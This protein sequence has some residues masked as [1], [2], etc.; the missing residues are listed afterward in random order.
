MPTAP[1]ELAHSR[2]RSRYGAAKNW[3]CVF[4]GLGAD[5]WAFDHD[6]PG[7]QYDDR[8][9][10]YSLDPDAYVCLCARC[11]SAYDR[12]ISQHG[13]DGVVELMEQLRS[14]VPD[15]VRNATRAGVISS[16]TSL[17]RLGYLR[18]GR[19]RAFRAFPV[20]QHSR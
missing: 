13:T 3:S 12:H 5:H 8:G 9:R 17:M 19:D 6:A 14:A 11:H 18:P 20:D 2:V 7:V 15:E 4:C 16:V 10:A 1:Y